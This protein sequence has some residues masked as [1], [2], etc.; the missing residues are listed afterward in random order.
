MA[1]HI[2]DADINTFFFFLNTPGHQFTGLFL[3][4]SMLFLVFDYIYMGWH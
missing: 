3:M 1:F 2:H 4:L